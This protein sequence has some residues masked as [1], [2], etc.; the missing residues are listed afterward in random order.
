MKFSKGLLAS[1]ISV[2]LYSCGGD[3]GSDPVQPPTPEPNKQISGLAIDGYLAAAQ[4]CLDL[5]QNYQCDDNE[6]RTV[7]DEQ[8][9][10]TLDLPGSLDTSASILVKAIPGVTIDLDTPDEFVSDSFYLLGDVDKPEVVSPVTTMV[11][12]RQKSGK[13]L[14]QAEQEVMELL[15]VTSK[16]DLY[17]D[18][19][20]AANNDAL[21]AQE[22]EKFERIQVVNQ[23]LTQVMATG[24]K[25]SIENG[26]DDSNEEEVTDLFLTKVAD[27]VL[28]MVVEQVDK[29]MA[30]TPAQEPVSTEDI[31]DN[32]Q[33]AAP[34]IAVSNEEIANEQV[35]PI[36]PAAPSQAVVD[37]L[38]NTFD[39]QVVPG[40]QSLSDYE[41]SLNG[42]INWLDID[43][44]PLQLADED[45][46]VG[47]VQVRVKASE[48]GNRSAGSALSNA[49]AFSPT[50]SAPDAPTGGAINDRINTFSWQYVD[51][52]TRPQDYQLSVDG[53]ST[54]SQATANPAQLGDLAYA[55]GDIQVRVSANPSTGRPASAVLANGQA[56]TVTPAAPAAPANPV[57][58]DL[59]NIFDWRA[60]TGFDTVSSYEYSLDGGSNWNDVLAKPL[61]IPD[62]N[63]N[64]GTVAVRVKADDTTGRPAG[65]TLTNPAPYTRA[66]LAAAAPSRGVVN[67]DD[68]TFGWAPVSGFSRA[69]DYE[70]QLNG[71][72]WQTAN[73]NPYVVGNIDIAA[74]ALKVRVKA[75]SSLGRPAGGILA[76]QTA[77][78][79]KLGAPAAPSN[80]VVNDTNNTFGWSNVTGFTR[81]SDYEVQINGGSWQTA[82]ANPY[83]VGDINAASGAVRVRVKADSSNNRPAG[84]ALASTSAFTQTP[85]PA[86]TPAPSTPAPTPAPT[87]AAPAAPTN[88]VVN[89]ADNTFSFTLVSG[90]SAAG[91][92]QYS[93]DGGSNWQPVTAVPIVLQDLNYASGKI[94]VRVSADSSTRRPAGQVLASTKEYTV[95]PAKPAAPTSG[96]VSDAANTFDW[97]FT[98]GFTNSSDYEYSVDAGANFSAV[99]AK[100]LA[101]ENKVYA[102][103]QV[104]VR[105]KQDTTNGRPASDVLKNT[106][107]YTKVAVPVAP[108]NGVVNDTANTF[109]WTNV[110]GFTSASDYELQISGGS[111]Q[112]AS[113]NPHSV[114]N[115][116]IESGAVKVRVKA[117]SSSGRPAG[118]IL[119]STQAFNK[120]DNAVSAP[121]RTGI[122]D[123]W[124]K[125]YVEFAYVSG[126]DQASLYEY[127][128]DGGSNWQAV[129]NRRIEIGN[130]DLS[131]NKIHIRVKARTNKNNAGASLVIDQAFTNTPAQAQPSA[132]S[133]TGQDD[134]ANTLTFS[135]VS[136]INNIADYE[137]KIETADWAQ[138][139]ST[140]ITLTDKAYAIGAIQVR[141]KED[142]AKR[143]PAGVIAKNTKAYT[144]KPPQPAAPTV[145][146]QDD[147][148]NQFGWQIVSG[149]SAASDYEVKINSNAWQT[150]T[151]NPTIVGNVAIAVGDV[152]VR[153]KANASNGRLAGQEAA[154]TKQYTAVSSALLDVLT[155]QQSKIT[156]VTQGITAYNNAVTALA[157]LEGAALRAKAKLLAE[158]AALLDGLLTLAEQTKA[159]LAKAIVDNSSDSSANKTTVQNAVNSLTSQISA[160]EGLINGA[161][162]QL[163]TAFTNASTG[164]NGVLISQADATITNSRFAKLDWAGHFIDSATAANQG[165]RCLLDTKAKTRTVWALLQ[166]GAADG[167][168]DVTLAVANGTSSGDIKAYYNGQEICGNTAWQ[169]PSEPQLATLKPVTISDFAKL[170][171]QGNALADSASDFH[172][173]YDKANNRLWTAHRG[174]DGSAK[175][176]WATAKTLPGLPSSLSN[177]GNITW[178]LPDEST[179]Q[180]LFND[181]K[182]ASFLTSL[183]D[184]NAR[185]DL[186]NIYWVNKETF[187]RG[188]Y[189][190]NIKNSGWRIEQS[191]HG[192]TVFLIAYAQ[193]T[194]QQVLTGEANIESAA[195]F[196]KHQ[197]QQAAFDDAANR[198]Q[199]WSSSQDSSNDPYAVSFKT[200]GQAY[201]K[202]AI[203]DSTHTAQTRM[204]TV[205][206]PAAP[207]NP[208][209]DDGANTF[210][211]TYVANFTQATDYEYS[212][213][214]GGS[215]QDAS[216]KPIDV[217]NN[218]IDAG[219]VK[220]RVKATDLV[221]A[222]G[223][224]ASA[225]AYTVLV[226]SAPNIKYQGGCY[227]SRDY[228]SRPS[229]SD[230]TL[231]S[232]DDPLLANHSSIRAFVS[233]MGVDPTLGHYFYLKEPNF[234]LNE[235]YGRWQAEDRGRPISFARA[236]CKL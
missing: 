97:T 110:Q 75:D 48:D 126:Y 34:D 167:K 50:P 105:V 12:M 184:A 49:Q 81:A 14:E 166:D 103:D 21:P 159:A 142:T 112:T 177:L 151:A 102:K 147:D 152:K 84:N 185:N 140:T 45:Y 44:K 39:W 57:V 165:W 129:S 168:D 174:R 73:S 160:L 98:S 137:V 40:Y 104:Q 61:A 83:S 4:V 186:R 11:K 79:K 236:V 218:A 134:A 179:W 228:D 58:N 135:K 36:V 17:V 74:G 23:V 233:A 80:G 76:N 5:N 93:V 206:A 56:Y 13:T 231:L 119:S 2:S 200:S 196:P 122:D 10:Y 197:G 18:F 128:K 9:N 86:P 212:T 189:A 207:T 175:I 187:G 148:K 78:T 15:D 232:K 131:A 132:P 204:V 51:G 150:A 195:N 53:G 172:Y 154:N 234:L 106:T 19:V 99:T 60:V 41:Y 170:D 85:A 176:D 194:N 193:L 120:F 47:S 198:Y 169:L 199:Y 221:P 63:Y 118:A 125:D 89:D 32:I 121:N 182:A 164:A 92:Y 117:D 209:E 71:G 235:K 136:S 46:A 162:A 101:L 139:S 219:D 130:I 7:T 29:T 59:V 67:D 116:N 90:Y 146:V 42:G 1:I 70:I 188:Y 171:S 124:G 217:G 201:A 114:S 163:K 33:Q 157:S 230:C 35:A 224:L 3:N 210:D 161:P 66:P 31:V 72:N 91:N 205:T 107:A 88:G 208:V 8:G 77:F 55:A 111:W 25:E 64:I 202:T 220:V 24:L 108:T 225:K 191:G 16:D 213:N 115:I 155:A 69:S 100:P 68:N 141:V 149:F 94:Q 54:W 181:A 27:S 211:W 229:E 52:F 158:Q 43:E 156:Q 87:P 62:L 190:I 203:A 28:P 173:W 113:A 223:A 38:N 178:Q 96:V 22:K 192:Y 37:N 143:R 123:S 6:Y 214:D 144:V 26:G 227:D 216:A 138:A 82:S 153:V 95:T 20:E 226:C 127:S 109:G 30:A 180:G 145:N 133:I 215:W 222:G 65:A 183:G